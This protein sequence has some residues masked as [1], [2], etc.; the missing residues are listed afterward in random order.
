MQIFGL[1]LLFLKLYCSLDCIINLTTETLSHI[2]LSDNSH[3]KLK[4]TGKLFFFVESLNIPRH[5][6]YKQKISPGYTYVSTSSVPFT[7]FSTFRNRSLLF[8]VPKKKPSKRRTNIRKTA[9][10]KRFPKN[11]KR[12]MMLDMY[13]IVK[14]TDGTFTKSRTIHENWLNLPN[15]SL[16]GKH[17]FNREVRPSW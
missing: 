16:D 17:I 3:F 11:Y 4:R 15:T 14:Y 7:S 12:P 1:T 6:N 13:D 8:A 5:K 2:N 10:M 9:W